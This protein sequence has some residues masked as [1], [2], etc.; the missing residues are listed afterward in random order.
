MPNNPHVSTASRNLGLDAAFDVL[1]SG[2]FRVY[3]GTQPATANTALAGN[4]QLTN[5]AFGVTAF[6][7]ASGGSK[8]ANAIGSASILA[9]STATWCTMIKSGGVRGT[10]T[11]MD[12]SAGTSGA[13]VNFNSV[14]FVIG[15]TCSITS[16]TVNQ[17]A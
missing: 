16:L 6:A 10:D 13:D 15:A 7:A 4:T 17:A 12:V 8:V 9:S 2:F 1:N 14:T 5:N 11:V 3:D